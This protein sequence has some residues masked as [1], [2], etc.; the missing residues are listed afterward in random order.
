MQVESTAHD[1]TQ[2]LDIERLLI[3]IVCPALDRLQG[4]FARAMT[5]RDDHL[6]VRL[7]LHDRIKHRETF[8]RAIGIGRQA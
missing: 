6:G 3:E 4:A 2:R 5:A 1:K 8:A 7:K